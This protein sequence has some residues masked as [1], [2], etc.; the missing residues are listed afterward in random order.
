MKL[1]NLYAG[2]VETVHL[3]LKKSLIGIVIDRFGTDISIRELDEEYCDVRVTVAISGQFFGWLAGIG[4][5]ICIFSPDK[6]R[7]QYIDYLNEIIEKHK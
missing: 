7:N 3:K 4:E 1:E 5:N 2:E 6:I